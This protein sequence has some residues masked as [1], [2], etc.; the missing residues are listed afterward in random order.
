MS[1]EKVLIAGGGVA[2]LEAMLALRALLGDRIEIELHAPSKD[3]VYRPFAVAEPFGL[4][5]VIR[6]DIA[7]L[8]ERCDA[9]FVR[10]SITGVFP[11]QRRVVDRSR[12][13]V[14]YDHLL[15]A[16]GAEM[17]WPMDGAATFWG[18]GEDGRV[19]AVLRRLEAGQVRKLVFTMPP[20]FGWPLPLYELAL[21]TAS[22]MRAAGIEGVQLSIVTPEQRPLEL[23]GAKASASAAALLEQRGI[24]LLGGRC[25]LGFESGLLSTAPEGRI[26]ADDVVSMPRLEGR[27]LNGVPSDRRGF[28][29]IDAHARVRGL[30]RVYAAGDTTDCPVK[31]G[32][33]AAAQ[34][35]AAADQIAAELGCL[36]A[37]APFE[38]VLRGVLVTDGRGDPSVASDH[39]LWW[40]PGKIAGKHL[41]PFLSEIAGRALQPPQPQPAELVEL[42]S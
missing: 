12:Q 41:V 4:A 19:S 10:T 6:F 24:E 1:K 38:R 25:P 32:G 33:L 36:N 20:D 13:E 17:L 42:A 7:D 14:P 21:L 3:V 40:P 15:L 9:R 5:E 30:E 11:G 37:P 35:D 22:R 31:Q 34:A 18:T 28:V 2:A 27:R 26:E 23:L 8:A 16:T 39:A 29:P